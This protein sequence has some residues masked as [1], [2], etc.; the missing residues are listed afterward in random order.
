MPYR[1]MSIE[2]FARH[3]GLDVRDVRR[4]ADR[5]RLPGHKVAGQWRFNRAQV[6]EWL[7]QEMPILAEARL[8]AI[9]RSMSGTSAHTLD[10]AR[11]TVTPLIGLDGV[12]VAFPARTKTSVLGELVK[13]A[14]RTGLLYDGDGLLTALDQRESLCSTALP[15]GIAIPHPRQPMPYVSAEQLICVGRS[16]KGIGFGAPGGGRTH[17]FFLIC[18]HTDR[19]HLHVLARLMRILEEANVDH[20]LE[21]ETGREMLEA[22][23]SAEREVVARTKHPS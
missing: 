20:L 21:V 12:D 8:V 13:L 22:L 11:L 16:A 6:T 7:Q 5:D 1:S 15:I 10:E 23:I 18:C 14:D 4:L 19:Y 2:E 9:E 3:V 17:L